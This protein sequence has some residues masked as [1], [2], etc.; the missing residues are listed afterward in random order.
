MLQ[1]CIWRH[2]RRCP[3]WWRKKLHQGDSTRVWR[4]NSLSYSVCRIANQFFKNLIAENSQFWKLDHFVLRNSRIGAWLKFL[5]NSLKK[6]YCQSSE[7]S[8]LIRWTLNDFVVGSWTQK[9]EL[10]I[11]HMKSLEETIQ[12]NL[13]ISLR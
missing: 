5:I 2:H 1:V 9:I 7:G 4:V 12:T 6:Y 10:G 3:E 11:K 13:S 8:G